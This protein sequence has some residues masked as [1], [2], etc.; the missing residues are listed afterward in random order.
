MAHL[1][2]DEGKK[3]EKVEPD[4]H[5]AAETWNK[6]VMKL[7]EVRLLW[8]E[9]QEA[10]LKNRVSIGHEPIATQKMLAGIVHTQR[11]DYALDWFMK[12]GLSGYNQLIIKN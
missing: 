6:V 1:K 5:P 12:Y 11:F 8:K 9:H 4:L 2:K 10:Y 3:P 7:E